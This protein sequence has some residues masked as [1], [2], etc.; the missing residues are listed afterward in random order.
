[1]LSQ[2]MIDRLSKEEMPCPKCRHVQNP[3]KWWEAW[4]QDGVQNEGVRREIHVPCE[5]GC[6]VY[7]RQTVPIFFTDRYGWHW[8]MKEDFKAGDR[9][10]YSHVKAPTRPRMEWEAELRNRI[11]TLVKVVQGP[12]VVAVSLV[13]DDLK[14]R[15]SLL[16]DAM[17]LL[18]R[19]KEER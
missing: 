11:G 9:V 18:E 3:V 5:G 19:V 14:D 6:G 4:Q 1:M 12:N 7:L 10:M 16:N 15:P 13:W 2:E 8:T 17:R